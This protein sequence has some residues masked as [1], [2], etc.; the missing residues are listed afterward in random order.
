M[1]SR[2]ISLLSER[3]QQ[4]IREVLDLKVSIGLSQPHQLMNHIPQAYNEAVY[5]LKHRIR[6]GTGII[7]QYQQ[8]D[9]ASA[10]WAM[11][12]PR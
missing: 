3:L 7:V 11:A 12:Y 2:Q 9:L 8:H 10:A 6:L 4:Q 1:F 5:A